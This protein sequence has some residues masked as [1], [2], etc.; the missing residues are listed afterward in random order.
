VRKKTYPSGAMG[1]LAKVLFE[2]IRERVPRIFEGLAWIG[3]LAEQH[4]GRKE[5][6]GW[7]GPTEFPVCNYY[8][9]ISFKTVSLPRDDNT[10]KAE[11]QRLRI[12]TGVKPSS[13]IKKDCVNGAAPNFIHS[14][15]A[16]HLIRTVNAC[17][18]DDED[19]RNLL[20]VHDC[21]YCLAP[22]AVKVNQIV[23]RE[24]AIMYSTYGADAG[25][26]AELG[27]E[28]PKLGNL[29]PVSVQSAEWLCI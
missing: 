17:F 7:Y 19:I 26:L 15:D 14:L 12:G 13:V 24:L 27:P 8:P 6:L 11:R 22:D 5:F 4:A 23:R 16:A 18:A 29:D 2:A 20:T 1:Y 28:P 10:K 25:P 9:E 21:F 3:N